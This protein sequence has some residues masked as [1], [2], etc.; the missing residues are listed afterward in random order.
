M[1]YKSVWLDIEKIAIV[2]T[3]LQIMALCISC[4]IGIFLTSK[5]IYWQQIFIIPL[6]LLFMFL[7]IKLNNK[8]CSK[9]L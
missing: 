1:K 7:I 5:H 6:H 3:L 9:Y 4:G 8:L 2:T